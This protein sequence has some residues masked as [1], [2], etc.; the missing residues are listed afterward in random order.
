MVHDDIIDRDT[1]R[2]G[3]DTIHYANYKSYS[4]YSK[5][6]DEVTNLSNSIALCMGD[7]GLYSANKIISSAYAKDKNLA[8]VL[9]CFNDTVL[10]TIRDI[11]SGIP[12][13]FFNSFCFSFSISNLFFSS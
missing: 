7:Y 11:S 10:N 2:R 6:L 9:N 4:R 12:L 5:D 13:C 3:K 8:R 1:L